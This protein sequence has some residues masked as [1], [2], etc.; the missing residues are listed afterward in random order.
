MIYLRNFVP[1]ANKKSK[2][3]SVFKFV[4]ITRVYFIFQNIHICNF[5]QLFHKL[6]LKRS[7]KKVKNLVRISH[8]FTIFF[9]WGRGEKE[10]P[11]IVTQMMIQLT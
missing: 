10:S 11:S 2:I 3:L 8:D 5:V 4:K 6:V 1:K 9:N 7:L